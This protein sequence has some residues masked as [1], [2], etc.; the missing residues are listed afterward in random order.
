MILRCPLPGSKKPASP[1]RHPTLGILGRGGAFR[2][3]EIFDEGAGRAI[4]HLAVLADP[5]LDAG[6]GHAHRVG[7]HLPVG[8]L[9]DEH[10]RLGLAVE[11][12]QVDA[13]RAVKVE[14]LG[15][16]GLARGIAHADARI[17]ERV[18]ER[19]EHQ[20]VPQPVAQPVDGADRAAVGQRGADPAGERHVVVKEPLLEPPGVLHADHDV[21]ELALEHPRRGEE[22]GGPDLAQVGHH[23][24]RA[25]GAVHAEPR[26]V[27]L[28]DR[29]D[30][31]ADPG[32]RQIGQ[33]LV[34]GLELVEFG[35]GAGGLDHV[36][37]R[38]HHAL[39]LAG[40]ARGVQHHAGAVV[41]QLGHPRLELARQ[42]LL[43][44][45][46]LGLYVR[47]P[48]HAGMVVFPHPALVGVEDLVDRV[49]GLFGLDDLVHLLLVAADDEARARVAQHIGHLGR[50]R[51]LIERHRDRAAHL[52]RHHRPVMRRPVAADDRH[53][54]AP[55]EPQRQ[56]PQRQRPDLG[57]RLGPGPALPDPEFFLAVS[58]TAAHLGRIPRQQRR[59]R[60]QTRSRRRIGPGSGPCHGVHLSPSGGFGP[61]H[62]ALLNPVPAANLPGDPCPSFA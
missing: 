6:R 41:I 37:V 20:Q 7:P 5:D 26:P 27:G 38:Q 43:G 58:R 12:L 23:R 39:G 2:V 54:I 49:V 29:E 35:R 3:V 61:R 30:E 1:G 22:I 24:V 13:Q 55:L 42:A 36:A 14:Y 18:L 4:E 44:G 16:N 40:G 33:H 62:R 60:P 10:R 50:D 17:A 25:L 15:A 59:N 48:V 51:V 34:G 53:V 9:G 56:E 21:G 11:L 8:L 47:Q 52:R 19:P 57:L 32:H 45:A 28:P 31:V 46:A